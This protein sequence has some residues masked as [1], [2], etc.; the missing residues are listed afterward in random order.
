MPRPQGEQD[1][2]LA[3]LMHTLAIPDEGATYVE[4]GYNVCYAYA[5]MHICTYAHTH[6]RT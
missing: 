1:T 6:I 2:R 3:R 4:I 5:H